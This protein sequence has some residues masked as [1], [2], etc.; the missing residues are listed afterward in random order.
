M[1]EEYQYLHLLK[2]I[3]ETGDTE[4]S[5]NGT[6]ISIFGA[7]MRFTLSGGTIP[8]ITTKKFAWKTCLKELLWFIKGSTNGRE[9]LEQG[10]K[11]WQGNGSRNFL[12][13]RGLGHLEEDDLGPIYGHQW[14]HFNAPYETCH[15]NYEGK[16]VDQ[17]QSIIDQLKDPEKRNSRRL[18]MSAWNPLQIDEMALPPC[19]ILVQFNVSRGNLLS[20]ALYQRSGD[21]GLGV[22]FNIASY[23]MLLCLIAKHCDLIP[24]EFVHNLGNA[25]IYK[26]HVEPVLKQLENTPFDFPEMNIKT[27]RERIEDYTLDDFEIINYKS[28]GNIAM[29]MRV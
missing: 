1:H 16:G 24:H 29:V 10:V 11:I 2:Q 3:L 23:C 14:R 7:S 18:V 20:C 12:D 4:N 15:T 17:L 26:E 25:H 21:M 13:G 5:R 9:L 8:F 27:K 19:H 6:T 22:P 28:H